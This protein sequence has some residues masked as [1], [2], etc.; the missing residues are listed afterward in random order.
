MTTTNIPSNLPKIVIVGGGFGGIELAKNLKNKEVQVLMF[1]RHNYH[2]FQPLLYQVATGGL[3][4]DSIAFPLRK[5]FKGHK[6][7]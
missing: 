1:D 3:E 5:I 7:F 6:N 2:T 4:A